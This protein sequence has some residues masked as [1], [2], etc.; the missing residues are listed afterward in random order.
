[1]TKRNMPVIHP[2]ELLKAELL[3]ASGLTITEVAAMLKVS[4]Q[5]I[6]NII[7]MKADISPE[8]ALRI[9]TV[10]GGTADI[11]LRLQAKY[12][13]DIAAKKISQYK[14]VPYHSRA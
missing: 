7:N 14:L 12:D 2:G 13:L 10:F 5:A 1:M 6:S 8:M 4:R 3:E 9:A 11:W